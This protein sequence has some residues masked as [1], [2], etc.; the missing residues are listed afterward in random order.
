MLLDGRSVGLGSVT[1]EGVGGAG[2]TAMP[3]GRRSRASGAG[4][5][6]A[7]QMGGMELF[8]RSQ[9]GSI[10]RATSPGGGHDLERARAR[11]RDPRGSRGGLV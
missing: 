6:F 11:L 4:H 3:G 8:G 1:L 7:A 5:P 9:A 2:S 10:R